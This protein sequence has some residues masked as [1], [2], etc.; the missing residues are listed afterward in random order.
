MKLCLE[1]GWQ[2]NYLW[3][4]GYIAVACLF[5]SSCY[6]HITHYITK[7]YT[8]IMLRIDPPY[9]FMGSSM[10]CICR[11]RYTNYDQLEPL[12]SITC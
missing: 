4:L 7:N 6:N 10:S 5:I 8:I 1:F 2:F 9:Y 11:P 12:R 3:C